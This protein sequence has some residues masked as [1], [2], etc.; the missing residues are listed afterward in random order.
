MSQ[1]RPKIINQPKKAAFAKI[2]PHPRTHSKYFSRLIAS[3]SVGNRRRHYGL[4]G[5]SIFVRRSIAKVD[6]CDFSSMTSI[7]HSLFTCERSITC[8]S[9]P[10]NLND[11]QKWA[12]Y[13]Y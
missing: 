11:E 9:N 6:A 8:I 7:T 1:Q 10:Q 2:K 13:H 12:N 5:A 3:P 4:F